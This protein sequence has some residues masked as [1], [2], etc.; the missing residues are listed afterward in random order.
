LI[1]APINYAARTIPRPR[2]YA[3]DH[4]RDLLDIAPQVMPITN[5]RGRKSTL[6]GEGFLLTPHHSI[7]TDFTDASA[8]WNIHRAEI[9]ALIQSVSGAD[10]VLV[11]AP[12]LLRFSE[13]SG[14]A[15]SLNNSM[16]A[17][18]AHVD[19][20]DVTA[21]AFVA[22]GVPAGKTIIR[23][24]HYNIWRALSD[25]PQD[26]PLAVCDAGSV[27][28]EDLIAADAVF[29]E[30]GKPEWSFE[31][32]VV[33]HNPAHRWHWFSDMTRDEALIFKTNDSD[34][35]CAHCVPH[36]AFDMPDCPPDAP[37]R[38]SIEMRATAYWFG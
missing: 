5:G 13:K 15:G 26:V 27:S 33:A 29:D 34:S 31:G 22:Q 4:S 1:R 24:A 14:K 12:G 35:S 16:P 3:N 37:S 19:I 25:P 6:D 8:V 20:S 32:W 9:A 17:R 7:V 10:E 11:T 18:F 23:H 30:T 38:T 21:A 2:Y 36:V 28:P